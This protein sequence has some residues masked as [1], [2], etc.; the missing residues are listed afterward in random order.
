MSPVPVRMWQGH[1]CGANSTLKHTSRTQVGSK[2]Q[3]VKHVGQDALIGS[4]RMDSKSLLPAALHACIDGRN[5]RGS[6]WQHGAQW[7]TVLHCVAVRCNNASAPAHA[8]CL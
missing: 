8:G 1:T 4:C 2:L 3:L 5:R 6:V 7:R